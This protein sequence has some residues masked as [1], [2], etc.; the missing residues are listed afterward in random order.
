LH[1]DPRARWT[2]STLAA[3]V[4][5]HPSHLARAFRAAHDCTV[6]EY[7]R[8][9]RLNALAGALALGDESIAELALAH[10]F[11]DQSHGTRALRRWLGTTP[12]ALRRAFRRSS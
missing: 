4:G 11:A 2:L 10:G 6:G 3:H 12:A 9:L 8:R 7:L 5:R 1:D